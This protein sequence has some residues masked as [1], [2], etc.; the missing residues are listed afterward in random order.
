MR[1]L[2][3]GDVHIGSRWAP[4]PEDYVLAKGHKA[5]LSKA[6]E[7]LN[8]CWAHM[9]ADAKKHR[10]DVIIFNGDLIDGGYIRNIDVVSTRNDD[11]IGA[12]EMMLAPLVKL[13]RKGVF[14]TWGTGFHTGRGGENESTLCRELLRI[15]HTPELYLD[16]PA[17]VIHATHH[18]SSTSHPMYE[19]TALLRSL[20]IKEL[21]LI[22]AY[23]KNGMPDV[24]CIIRSHRHR[25]MVIESE[26]NRLVVATAP[27][28]L[29]TEY[30]W[31][32]APDSEPQVGYVW[33]DA[34]DKGFHASKVRFQL[35]L[36]EVIKL[37]E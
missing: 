17:G 15:S 1:I 30:V 7:Y 3:I 14:A 10:P 25:T 22:R 27:W 6:Q 24:R 21:E 33:I 8:E 12:A 28:M 13:A 18:V 4:W 16:S 26:D 35:P 5:G 36:P 19:A 11:Q 9:I 23:G 20:L 31:K 2:V 29:K 32:V 37:G 34:T